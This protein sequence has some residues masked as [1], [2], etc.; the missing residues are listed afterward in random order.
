ME[1]YF[2][3]VI[4]LFFL[5]KVYLVKLSVIW[6][7]QAVDS[8]GFSQY[9][10]DIN[11]PPLKTAEATCYLTKNTGEAIHTKFQIR[12]SGFTDADTPLTY[13]WFYEKN[14]ERK[15]CTFPRQGKI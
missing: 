2:K 10:I 11:S 15:P 5:G 4:I 6:N 12:C 7:K 13:S 8:A 3:P 1:F 14:N 9:S